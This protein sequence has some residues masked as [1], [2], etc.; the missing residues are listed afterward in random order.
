MF[1]N[2]SLRQR[3]PCCLHCLCLF[4]NWPDQLFCI[5]VATHSLPPQP[6]W[7]LQPATPTVHQAVPHPRL[8]VAAAPPRIP[9]PLPPPPP[10]P[11]LAPP[12]ASRLRLQRGPWRAEG[13]SL[14]LGSGR[15]G[16][17]HPQTTSR[18]LSSLIE[19]DSRRFLLR[20]FMEVF[21][22]PL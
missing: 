17:Q 16:G 11:Q 7:Y 8:V 14:P 1:E 3:I 20:T 19:W 13:S 10:S 5:C 21:S 2:K 4:F 12:L 6:N 22:S 9:R 18:R 15:M